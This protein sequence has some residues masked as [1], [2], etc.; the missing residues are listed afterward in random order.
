MLNEFDRKRLQPAGFIY[1]CIIPR[2]ASKKQEAE[3]IPV[4]PEQG[5][6]CVREGNSSSF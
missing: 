6:T 2:G 1:I 5:N 3:M 4:E